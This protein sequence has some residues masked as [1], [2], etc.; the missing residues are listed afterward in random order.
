MGEFFLEIEFLLYTYILL[1][2]PCSSSFQEPDPNCSMNF[3]LLLLFL[4]KKVRKMCSEDLSGALLGLEKPL[5][6]GYWF[7]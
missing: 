7:L 5:F 6:D 1:Y 2:S 3:L 4:N